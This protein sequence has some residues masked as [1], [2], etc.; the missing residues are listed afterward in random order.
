MNNYDNIELNDDNSSLLNSMRG[1]CK[2]IYLMTEITVCILFAALSHNAPGL[3][4]GMTVYERDIPYQETANED[5]ILD[6][7][8]NREYVDNETVPDGQLVAF[9]LVMPFLMILAYSAF[10]GQKND[11]HS[12]SC[13][14][15]FGTGC[16]TFITNWMKLY[17]GYFRPNFYSYCGFN[18]EN[19]ECEADDEGA[20]VDSRK[21]FPSGHS[22]VS[23]YGMTFLTIFLI[24]KIGMYRGLT[25]AEISSMNNTTAGFLF[26]KRL[27]TI[28]ATSPLFFAIFVAASRVHDDMHHPADIVAGSIIG[29]ICSSFSYGLW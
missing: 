17:M 14:F 29:M 13:A 21:S 2:N 24:G 9:C 7:Y 15:L 16:T 12:S 23:F 19:L 1:Y 6:S 25:S 18:V 20:L 22:S 28:V 11:L 4:F 8:I 5:V 3:I 26:K 27:L 10:F